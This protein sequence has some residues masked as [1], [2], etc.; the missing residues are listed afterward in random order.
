[1][2]VLIVDDE[3]LCRRVL[4]TYLACYATCTC[5]TNGDDALTAWHQ[6][7]AVGEPYDLVCLDIKM[8]GKDGMEVLRE[9]RR[10][11][12][13]DA[14]N[15][16]TAKV[17]M[18]SSVSDWDSVEE[19]YKNHCDAYLVKPVTRQQMLRYVT[20]LGLLDQQPACANS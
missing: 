10:C 1:M 5:V 16:S 6:A 20:T 2:R 14:Q 13:C 4:E 15:Q 19:A 12:N 18:V 17:V 11:E 3:T 8:P 9:I 7:R